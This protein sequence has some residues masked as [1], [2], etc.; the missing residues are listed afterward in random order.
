MNDREDPGAS[1]IHYDVLVPETLEFEVNMND[2]SAKKKTKEAAMGHH[3]PNQPPAGGSSHPN[4]HPPESDLEQSFAKIRKR[5]SSLPKHLLKIKRRKSYL[6]MRTNLWK[7]KRRILLEKS[8][9]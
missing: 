4:H 7:K 5:M 3:L 2:R 6:H 1:Y 9:H 8:L